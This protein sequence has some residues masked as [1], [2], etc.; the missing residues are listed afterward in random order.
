MRMTTYSVFLHVKNMA[1][2]ICRRIWEL[3]I[4]TCA[5]AWLDAEK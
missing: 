2:F 3:F 5:K 4:S 1:E